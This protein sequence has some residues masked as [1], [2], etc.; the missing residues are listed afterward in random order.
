MEPAARLAAFARRRAVP[1]L[2]ALACGLA[3]SP[4]PPD[5][6]VVQAAALAQTAGLT[7]RLAD[8][9]EGR[10]WTLT[11]GRYGQVADVSSAPDGTTFVLDARH[12]VV[13]VLDPD[14]TPRRVVPASDDVI[15]TARRLDAGWDGTF[16]VLSEGA[17]TGNRY[18]YR[19][20]QYAADGARQAPDG[21]PLL[22]L[23]LY[24]A[25]PRAYRD[26][27]LHPD[28][29][30]FVSRAGPEN[31]YIQGPG[32]T[33]TPTPAGSPPLNAIDVLA[34]DGRFLTRFGTTDLCQPDS[35]DVA[36]DGTTYVVNLCP[37]P[38]GG[39]DGPGPTPTPRPSFASAA[40]Q[41]V[42]PA[43][44][45]EAEREGVLVYGPDFVLR[46]KHRATTID[47]I[48]VGPAGTFVSRGVELFALGEKEP[49]YAA[50]SG[51]TYSAFYGHVVFHLDV[52][53]GGGLV[54]SMNHC[55]FQ[56]LLDFPRPT[57]RPAEPFLRGALDQ[58]ELEGPTYPLR[59]AA[60]D[61]LAVL[62]GRFGIVGSRPRQ[63]YRLTLPGENQ[64]VQR[65]H[66][67]GSLA[68]QLGVCG[69]SHA[70]RAQDV[71]ADGTDVYTVDRNL[72][73]RRPDDGI[74]TWT[75][76]P[77][78]ADDPGVT[79]RLQAVSARDGQVAALDVG[80]GRVIVLD[81]AMGERARW[82]VGDA[83]PVDL[84]LGRE[85]IYL[86]ES[87]RRRVLV[88]DLAGRRLADWPLHDAAQ[89]LDVGPA[90]DDAGS[91]GDLFV[92]GQ[93]GWAYRYR[94]HGQLVAAWPLP[95]EGALATDLA[96]GDDGRVFVS[97][98]DATTDLP[99]M[100]GAG[101]GNPWLRR[102]GI[103]VFEAA[104]MPPTPPPPVPEACLA[105]PDKDAAPARLP[106][107]NTVEVRLTVTGGCPGRVEP[108]QV[109]LVLD[110]SR[111]MS[112]G[113]VLEAA[114]DGALALVAG[115]DPR[116]AQVGLATFDDQSAL[117]QPLTSDFAAV[118]RR[119]AAAEAGGDTRLAE[120]L[121]AAR[122]ELTG[123]RADP[124][125]RRVVVVVT[126]GAFKDEPGPAAAALRGAGVGVWFLHYPSSETSLT[127][128]ERLWTL[129]GDAAQVL[130]QP[131]PA[132]L[133]A[134][135]RELAGFRPTL[136]LFD[137]I[138]VRDEIPANMR[139]VA[140]SARPP[141][142]V[143]GPLLTWS[144]SDVAAAQRTTLTYTLEPLAVGTW[145]TN[146]RATAVYT[147]ALGFGGGLTFPLPWVTVYRLPR[148]NSIYLPYLT[149]GH[150]LRRQRPLDVVLA[151]D[152]STSM[153]D[154]VP[155]GG[156]K[157]DAAVTA[158]GTFLDLLRLPADRAALVTFDR[159]ARP[160]VGLSG[161]RAALAAALG[162][163]QTAEGTRIDLGLAASGAVLADGG[164]S[165]ARPVVILLTDGIQS[166]GSTQDVL[167]QAGMLRARGVLV[168][169]IGLGADVAPDL[170]RAVATTPG[171][172]LA[173]PT[174]ADLAQVYR[175][176]AERLACE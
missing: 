75:F 55:Y 80:A 51:E 61:Q 159:Q 166:A 48:A 10:P 120:G 64:V 102:A 19:I 105:A 46:Q 38:F 112:F 127:D 160:L 141:A 128:R 108:A 107:G 56:G 20:D 81:R 106:L 116:A 133:A 129:A 78:L 123:A 176:L 62:Q 25:T 170:L 172:Y 50:P 91:T 113:N 134:L 14:G 171:R 136:G 118:E 161:D 110:T 89:G 175:Q 45:A 95:N 150:C 98:L 126:D 5:P 90:G 83:V 117:P 168:Y 47:D 104:A 37:S 12:Q 76:W 65:W 8:T 57:S 26:L 53:A 173:S 132:A 115:L 92:L 15:W 131:R 169:T 135:A 144:L 93:G 122:G 154:G 162:R 143:E 74:P 97:F 32:P 140:G 142:R 67:D 156:T 7:Y 66:P 31:P 79:T 99:G 153:G 145:P 43:Q 23:R 40:G 30:I 49:L 157:L 69:Q 63:A 34:P 101:A 139:Y 167:D 158:A 152:T 148:Q 17:Q 82:D 72:L 18:D 41:A 29:R 21:R 16:F 94:P 13:H 42:V 119:L 137:R 11:P 164:R 121:D 35:L 125:A 68:S 130:E 163:V 28:G 2:L 59:L 146:V 58:P 71:A 52:P 6:G 96:V 114:K 4:V 103:W 151:L 27:A 88:H 165:E 9:W 111:S 155:G 86:A 138:T 24:T 1:A 100:P 124:G 33:A 3:V 174:A 22:S 109:M 77:G 36:A 73:Q 60:G 70:D 147:D 44:A 87:G 149:R 54:A 84:A 85:R 39:D